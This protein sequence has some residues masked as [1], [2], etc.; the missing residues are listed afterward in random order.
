MKQLLFVLIII[1]ILIGCNTE[2][3]ESK[4]VINPLQLNAYFENSD[5]P[6]AIMG[7]SNQNG[8]MDWYAFGPSVWGGKDTINEN[9]IFRIYS[10]TKA[11]ASV[12]AMQLVE[13]NLIGLDD[14][15]DELM[16]EMTSIPILT[17][18]GELVEAKKIITL[19]HLLTHT[20]GFGYAFLD[21]ELQTF[22][23]KEWKYDDLPRL[24]EA[25]EQWHYGTN[26]DWIGRII[27]KISE[28]DLET[29][30]RKNV[31]GPIKMNST[32]FNVPENLK[33][34]IVSWGTRDSIGF[35]E[36]PRIPIEPVTTFSAGGGLFG[37]PKDYLSFLLCMMNSGK[38]EGGQILKPETVELMSNN[39]LPNDLTLNTGDKSMES[40]THGLAW[41]IED[42]E[43]EVIRSK[44]SVYW[45][46]L[47]N[48][49]YS[50]DKEKDV[51]IVYF[52]NFFPYKDKETYDFYKLFEK[53]VYLRNKN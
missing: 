14:P 47:A 30:L 11:I 41:A 3:Q 50:L 1:S 13:Q 6:A 23:R 16:P 15:L 12:A 7:Y 21:P 32:W 35:Q 42:S 44:G 29:Y 19:R 5:L 49:Y 34:N 25:G 24:F 8:K 40:D 48:S 26:L 4:I 9:N 27:E 33:Q 52:T 46:G 51:A 17:E 38:Y 39:H 18:K 36:Y 10:M 2:K 53:E 45:S 31:T 20:A 28:E 37:S 43:D 22:D